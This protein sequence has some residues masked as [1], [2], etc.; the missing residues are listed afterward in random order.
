M[1]IRFPA[2]TCGHVMQHMQTPGKR[3]P[4]QVS[5]LSVICSPARTVCTLRVT[6][7]GVERKVGGKLHLKLNLCLRPIANKYHEEKTQKDFEKSLKK[8]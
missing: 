3:F 4:E 8:A 1:D 6:L 5:V 7:L 2:L